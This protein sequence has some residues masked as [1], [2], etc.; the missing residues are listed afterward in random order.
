MKLRSL[1]NARRF[2]QFVVVAVVVLLALM[3]STIIRA[4]DCRP[5]DSG[6]GH[7]RNHDWYKGLARPGSFTPGSCCNGLDCRTTITCDPGDNTIG[8]IV[9]RVC[10]RVPQQTVINTLSPDRRS[11]VCAGNTGVIYCVI[12]APIGG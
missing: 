8:V 9:D 5:G 4:E 7:E 1:L 6:C 12:I 10:R 2:A 11:H 3:F